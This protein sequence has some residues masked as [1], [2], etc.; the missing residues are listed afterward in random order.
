MSYLYVIGPKEG[1]YKLGY[2]E[3]PAKRL[4]Q[5]QTGHPETLVL[6]YMTEVRTERV[7]ELEKALHKNNNH[8]R[9]RGEWFDMPLDDAIAEVNFVRIRY[10]DDNTLK[11][12]L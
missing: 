5:F 6:H 11:Y 7:Q 3:N 2:S 4:Q 8:H 9:V 1:P 10:E 12:F